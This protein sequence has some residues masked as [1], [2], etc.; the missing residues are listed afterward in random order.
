[1]PWPRSSLRLG[2]LVVWS[3]PRPRLV[4][5]QTVL[6]ADHVS[7]V[8]Q[9]KGFTDLGGA[10]VASSGLPVGKPGTVSQTGEP[11]VR[12]VG[13][14]NCNVVGGCVEAD[15]SV[16]V[17]AA[18]L[19]DVEVT[20]EVDWIV[21]VRVTVVAVVAGGWVAVV[22]SVLLPIPTPVCG[23]STGTAQPTPLCWQ[24]QDFLLYD[25]SSCQK[26][27]P[28]SQLNGATEWPSRLSF[29]PA[30]AVASPSCVR[31]AGETVAVGSLRTHS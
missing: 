11:I 20:V 8:R 4:Q 17:V 25:H 16:V 21:H 10:P 26:A 12:V 30:A 7:V 29:A 28:D 2:L 31:F 9:L 5:H 22:V 14:V 23:S 27:S 19:V 24:H 1:M 6:P 18:V 15:V 3:Q 13:G